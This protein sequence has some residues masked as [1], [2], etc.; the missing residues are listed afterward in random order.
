MTRPHLKGATILIVEDEPLI[1][2][3]MTMALVAAGVHVT[4]TNTVKHARILVE[5]DGLTAATIDNALPDG[6]G[7]VLCARL[8]ELGVPFLVYSGTKP[9]DGPCKDAPYITKPALGGQ[10]LDAME[11]LIRDAK[12]IPN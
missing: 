5:S 6:N 11:A 12:I 2:M 9:V 8:K 3:D 7:T 10:L 1:V 4:S